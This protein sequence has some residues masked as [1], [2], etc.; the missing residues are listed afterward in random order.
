MKRKNLI[1]A[2]LPF[3]FGMFFLQSCEEE[4]PTISKFG[5][6]S[7][8]TA[9]APLDAALIK[10]TGTTAELKWA[11][12]DPDGDAPLCDVYFGT[13][14][15]PVLF[16]AGHTGLSLSVPVAE[17]STYHWYVKMYDANK[18]MTTGPV[19]S[20]SVEVNYTISNFVGKY[21]CDEPGYAK[22]ACNLKKIDDSTVENDNFWD[23][24]FAVK[25][26]FD[27]KG[28]VNI[29]PVVVPQVKLSATLT[30]D[31]EIT[32]SGTFNNKTNGFVVEYYVKDNKNKATVYDH[33]VHTFVKK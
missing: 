25:Y 12:T 31:I 2:I 8:P 22:Y 13:D 26:K 3:L 23:S 9:V 17:G 19:W 21:E 11:T 1:I 15:D 33:N 16:K 18:V 14:E 24:G 10:V 29:I 20:F 5:A 7:D 4:I 6:F 27:N 32:G 30:A 28:K